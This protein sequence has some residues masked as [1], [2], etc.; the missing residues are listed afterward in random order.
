MNFLRT[1]VGRV[2]R[3]LLSAICLSAAMAP[4]ARAS[5]GEPYLA[6][7]EIESSNDTSGWSVATL[8]QGFSSMYLNYTATIPSGHT[9]I[10]MKNTTELVD[11]GSGYFIGG[12]NL[13]DIDPGE[14]AEFIVTVGDGL[15]TLTTYTVFVTRTAIIADPDSDNDGMPDAYEEDNGLTVGI[16]DAELDLDGDGLCNICEYAFG[17]DPD[18]VTD[19]ADPDV[20][21]DSNGF[22][23]ISY[24]RA[25]APSEGL[26]Y[27]V[28]MTSDLGIWETIDV[29]QTNSDP[30]NPVWRDNINDGALP[31][32]PVRFVR[33]GLTS[34]L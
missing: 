4:M 3:L 17:S 20:T 5:S 13:V 33:V 30:V 25:I 12:S 27:T 21:L 9:Q 1:S 31:S 6:N 16:D 8:D 11:P 28:E 14:T 19:H 18:D 34:T 2:W 15:F 7:L 24:T 32:P 29:I 10:R 22:L 26:I 23:Q